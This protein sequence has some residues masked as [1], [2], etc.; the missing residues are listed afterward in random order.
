MGNFDF[1][2]SRT[3]ERRD[4]FLPGEFEVVAESGA[5][6]C[7]ASRAPGQRSDRCIAVTVVDLATGGLGLHTE[8]YLPRGTRGIVRLPRK[9]AQTGQIE[10]IERVVEIRRAKMVTRQPLY[11]AG[12]AFTGVGGFSEE[13][14]REVAQTVQAQH[15][16]QDRESGGQ[17]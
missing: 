7:F 10:H 9:N 8:T 4:V 2:T 3:T 1:L 13:E 12:A 6:V 16:L 17:A 14:V 15:H 5:Q 11:S